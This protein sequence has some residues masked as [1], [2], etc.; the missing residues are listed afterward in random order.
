MIV[1]FLSEFPRSAAFISAKCYGAVGYI[2]FNHF[3][4]NNNYPMPHREQ[5][6]TLLPILHDDMKSTSL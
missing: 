2:Y 4:H 5:P 1:A 6:S 3:P